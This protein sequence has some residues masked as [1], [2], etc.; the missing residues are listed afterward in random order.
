MLPAAPK[1]QGNAN[2]A[3]SSFNKICI[4]FIDIQNKAIIVTDTLET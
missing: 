1:I 4:I 3:K 2:K